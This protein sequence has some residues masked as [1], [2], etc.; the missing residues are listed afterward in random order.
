MCPTHNTSSSA[1]H[2]LHFAALDTMHGHSFLTSSGPAEQHCHDPRPEQRGTSA[3][4]PPPTGY[5]PNRI[6]DDRDNMHLTE[7]GQ[8]SELEDLRAKPLFYSQS[9]FA[10]TYDSAES[11]ATHPE[12]L[13]TLHLSGHCQRFGLAVSRGACNVSVKIQRGVQR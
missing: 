1:R 8:F 7:D 10:L 5:E 12:L 11:I 13:A 6:V 9:I 3:E 2:V 4:L